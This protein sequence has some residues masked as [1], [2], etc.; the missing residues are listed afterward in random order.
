MANKTLN[1]YFIRHGRQDSRLCNDDSP[2][3]EAGRM[4]A[5]LL[6]ERLSAFHFDAI[7]ASTLK[8][9]RE[10]GETIASRLDL[11]LVT[12]KRLVEIDWG[13]FVGQS[14]DRMYVENPDFFRERALRKTD[15]AFPGGECGEDVYRRVRPLIDEIE[16]SEAENVLIVAHGGLIRALIPGLLG[17]PFATKQA[18]ASTL[19]NTSLTVFRRSTKTGLYSLE[20]LN[21][22]AHLFSH[23]ELLRSNWH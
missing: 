5:A 16:A 22:H 8:R 14:V 17:L 10:T 15:L 9:A 3:S 11:P 20:A 19:E 21:D 13:I 6:A 12:D 4:Q 7:Y 18:F 23:P 1:L 2:L